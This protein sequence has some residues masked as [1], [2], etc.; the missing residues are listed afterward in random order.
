MKAEAYRRRPGKDNDGLS[1]A[2]SH[3]GAKAAFERG[4]G[5]AAARIE[6]IEGLELE[7]FRSDDE[8]GLI[9][10]LPDP[11]SD[12]DLAMDFADK[13]VAIS[14]FTHDPWTPRS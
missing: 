1:V 3:E 5:V 9:K 2:S 13:L 11:E 8:H 6:A 12:Y 7:L 10:G 4:Y 14:H